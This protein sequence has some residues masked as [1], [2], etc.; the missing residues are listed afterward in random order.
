MLLNDPHFRKKDHAA[1]W[2]HIAEHLRAQPGDF[3]IALENLDRWEQW[4]R[5]HPAPLC[6][7]RRRIHAA[8][9]SPAA[10]DDLLVRPAT[11]NHD[12]E[13]LKS[14]SPFVGLPLD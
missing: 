14:C 8:Q 5:V 4:G 13:P 11:A 6:E 2:R 1:R 3:V 12:A 7:W 10:I 9:A